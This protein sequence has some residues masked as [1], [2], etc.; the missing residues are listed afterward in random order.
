MK[1][2]SREG[3]R[4]SHYAAVGGHIEVLK[5]LLEFGDDMSFSGHNGASPLL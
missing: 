5:I 3:Q 2:K 4:A 1:I